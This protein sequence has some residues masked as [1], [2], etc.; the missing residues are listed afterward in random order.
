MRKD[1]TMKEIVL[2]DRSNCK[3]ISLLCK[4]YGVSVNIDTFSETDLYDVYLEEISRNLTSYRDVKIV[5]IHGPY[6]DLCLGSKDTFIKSATMAR[7]EYAYKIATL[8]NCPNIILHHGYIPGTSSPS[9]WVKRAKLF[10]EEF[11]SDKDNSI[12][13]HIENQ[14]EDT[15][16]LISEV[17]SAVSDNRLNICLDIGHAN[18]NSKIPILNWIEQLNDKI[19]FVHLHNNNGL[20][21]QHLDFTSGTIDFKEICFALEKYVPNC[22][23]AIE[24][25]SLDD[26]K[27]SI[28]WL[29]DN[30]YLHGRK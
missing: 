17:V 28:Q 3:G 11:L 5:S 21:D 24:T 14:F 13:I 2:C 30:H 26:A 18:L 10:F 19:S 22:I 6:R 9:N 7:F 1:I 8:L 27:K 23:W 15:P 16:I 25:N 20:T 29:I 4:Q 12:S